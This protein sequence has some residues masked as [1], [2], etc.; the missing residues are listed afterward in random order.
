MK[1]H[2][3]HLI[4]IF[5]LVLPS[6]STGQELNSWLENLKREITKLGINERGYLHSIGRVRNSVLRD[7]DLFFVSAMRFEELDIQ[8]RPDGNVRVSSPGGRRSMTLGSG[9]RSDKAAPVGG[10]CGHSLGN[11]PRLSLVTER[12]ARSRKANNLTSRENNLLIYIESFIA[13]LVLDGT[14]VAFSPYFDNKSR[15]E[16]LMRGSH[17]TESKHKLLIRVQYDNSQS[18]S[19]WRALN[20]KYLLARA[21][22]RHQISVQLLFIDGNRTVKEMRTNFALAYADLNTSRPVKESFGSSG[23]L[24]GLAGNVK[25]FLSQLDCLANYSNLVV[26]VAGRLVLDSGTDAGLS[27]G[28]QLL[29]MPNSAYFKKRGLLSGVDQIAIARVKKIDALQSELEIEEGKVRLEDGVEFF[30]RPLLELI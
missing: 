14:N 10:K 8:L 28:D 9:T 12:M 15:Y 22:K 3:L 23:E 13:G 17:F 30:V 19:R 29:L 18:E 16:N 2:A 24:Q 21:P 20:P 11:S 27:E 4:L 26:A 6:P 25:S 5:G 7:E 1:I